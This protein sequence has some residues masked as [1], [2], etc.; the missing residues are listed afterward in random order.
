MVKLNP[1]RIT[2]AMHSEAVAFYADVPAITQFINIKL[3]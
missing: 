3:S 1:F 2:A